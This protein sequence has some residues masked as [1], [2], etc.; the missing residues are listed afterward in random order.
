MKDSAGRRLGPKKYEGQEVI[1]GQILL[2]QRGTKFYP[3]ENVGIGKDHTLYALEPGIVRYYLD[4]FHPRRKFIGVA[5]NREYLL[6]KEHFEPNLRRFGR[7]ILK[8]PKAAQLE[9]RTLPRKQELVKDEILDRLQSREL[10]RV[11]LRKEFA[12]ILESQ[13]KPSNLTDMEITT[14]YLIRL[15][16]SLKNGFQLEDA[17]FYSKSY[18]EMQ[19]KL[20]ANKEK[21]EP[22]KLALSLEQIETITKSLDKSVC[23]TN[24]LK[25]MAYISPEEKLN[26]K[27]AL[28]ETLKTKFSN[29]VVT[30]KDKKLLDELFASANEFLTLS[31]EVHLRRKFMKPVL[32]EHLAPPLAKESVKDKKV[33]K[34]ATMINCFN[35]EK[36]RVDNIIRS[37]ESFPNRV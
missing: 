20:K 35:Y 15:R 13:N 11:K 29:N 1:S 16:S 10:E 22:A 17:Q 14:S 21:W 37:K 2:R 23:F 12:S 25:L 28:M 36:R 24:K 34:K 32:S 18:L 31:E 4:P 3:G 30:R 33:L 26:K 7:S 9:E 5:L 6:P 8:N 19:T 27:Q